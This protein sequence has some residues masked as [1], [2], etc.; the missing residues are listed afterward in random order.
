MAGDQKVDTDGARCS[1]EEGKQ[2]LLL[3]FIPN[4]GVYKLI[5]KAPNTEKMFA[6]FGWMRVYPRL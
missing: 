3:P 1:G 2:Q 5:S 6:S 4:I